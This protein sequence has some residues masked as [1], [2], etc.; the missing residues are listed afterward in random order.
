MVQHERPINDLAGNY[1]IPFFEIDFTQDPDQE[2]QLNTPGTLS[3]GR[4]VF[5]ENEFANSDE[6]Y[7]TIQAYLD[8]EIAPIEDCKHIIWGNSVNEEIDLE[9]IEWGDIVSDLTE[10]LGDLLKGATSLH[11]LD[12]E[13][14]GNIARF[15]MLKAFSENESLYDKRKEFR[16]IDEIL[17]LQTYDAQQLVIEAFQNRYPDI[18]A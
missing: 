17:W 3:Y 6:E 2:T 16:K 13:T 4:F 9:N 14:D 11:Y 7:G 12:K 18:E 5:D 10:T 15:T 1:K 8:F